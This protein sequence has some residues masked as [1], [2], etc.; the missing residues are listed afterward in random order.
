MVATIGALAALLGHG[1]KLL[2]RLFVI[3]TEAAPL[4][5]IVSGVWVYD[6][7]AAPIAAGLL[8]LL[9]SRRPPRP[10]DRRTE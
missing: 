4:L 5:L 7:R 2:L 6:H 1:V 3:L 10:T 8:L 9:P